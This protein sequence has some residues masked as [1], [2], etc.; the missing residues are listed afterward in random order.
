MPSPNP[1]TPPSR[2]RPRAAALLCAGAVLAALAAAALVGVATRHGSAMS[3]DSATYVAGARNLVAGNGYSDFQLIPITDW[4]PGLS[5][6]LAGLHFVGVGALTAARW[7]NAAALAAL[8]LLAFALARRHVSRGWLALAAA[9]IA[10]VAPAMLGVFGFIWTEPVFCTLAMAVLLVLSSIARDPRASWWLIAAAGLLAGVAFAYRYAGITLI[11]VTVIAVAIGAWGS[12]PARVAGR[13]AGALGLALVLPAVIV[14]RNATHGSLTGQRIPSTETLHGAFD[15]T[16]YF[17]VGWLLAD[18]HPAR[19]LGTVLVAVVIVATIGGVA[20]RI[21]ALGVGSPP[22]RALWPLVIFVA[23]YAIYIF[24]TEFA[25][26]ID[27]PD[28]RIFSPIFAPA[29]ILIMVAVDAGLDRLP[30]RVQPALAVATGVVVT[31]WIAAMLAVSAGHARA[32]G[33]EAVRFTAD[34]VVTDRWTGSAFMRAVQGLPAGAVV[35]S[36]QPGG[37]YLA[38]GHEPITYSG[39]PTAYP[40]IPVDR[41]TTTLISQII[42]ARGPVYLAWSLPNHRPNLVTPQDLAARGVRLVPVL[43]TPRG[44][45]DRVGG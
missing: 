8:V 24:A 17:L 1:P 22:A 3:P 30:A 23:G 11:V 40:P 44:I 42:A 16:E 19:A 37:V 21:H 18:H 20:L 6:T 36:N 5:L 2:A 14:A 38:T 28:D 27:P 13:A 41:Q 12:R 35:Y 33:R 29:A 10:G 26:S 31:V 45:I 15:S 43:V 9:A 34:G 25:T 4:P 32:Y 7:L 39:Q